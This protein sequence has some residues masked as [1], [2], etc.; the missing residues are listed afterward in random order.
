[1]GYIASPQVLSAH[2]EDETVLL[3]ME[4]KRY[5]RLNTTA[6]RIWQLLEGDADRETILGTLVREFD[7]EQTAAEEALDQLLGYLQGQKLV[8]QK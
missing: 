7:V 6:Q 2:L 4:S 5:F 8:S 1:M 3:D